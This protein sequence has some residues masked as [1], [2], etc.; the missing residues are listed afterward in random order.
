MSPMHSM[1]EGQIPQS[2]NLPKLK[3]S[4]ADALLTPADAER[5]GKARKSFERGEFKKCLEMLPH[6]SRTPEAISLR[7]VSLLRLD[8]AEDALKFL[9]PI[10]IAAGGTWVNRE[11][12]QSVAHNLATALLLTGRPAGCLEVLNDLRDKNHP[13]ANQ[14]R[15]AIK[16]WSRSLSWWSRLNWVIGKIEP[17][18]CRIELDFA[19][20]DYGSQ[21]E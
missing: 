9:R 20:G 3:K 1:P 19:P 18:N 8:R 17:S 21:D 10:T 16:R 15:D 2:N 13:Y 7:A 5:M 4:T 11:L 12:P 6:E 14:L